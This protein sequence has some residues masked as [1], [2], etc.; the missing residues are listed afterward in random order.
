MRLHLIADGT[1]ERGLQLAVHEIDD[2]GVVASTIVVP[3]TGGE[4]LVSPRRV[5]LLHVGLRAHAIQV[6]VKTVQQERE[7]F[8]RGQS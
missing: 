3:G 4:F 5:L 6:L 7:Q 2:D 1:D 8:L